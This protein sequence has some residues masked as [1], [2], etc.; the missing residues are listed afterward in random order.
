VTKHN[1][2]CPTESARPHW[3][4]GFDTRHECSEYF[5]FSVTFGMLHLIHSLQDGFFSTIMVSVSVYLTIPLIFITWVHNVEWIIA[6]NGTEKQD[7]Q[8]AYVV[9]LRHFRTTTVA[10]E[11]Q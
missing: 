6:N 10:V 4:W 8:R 1:V 2:Q 3:G 5:H 9:T 11:R 7:R